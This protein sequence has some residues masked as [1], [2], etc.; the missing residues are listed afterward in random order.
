MQILFIL[1]RVVREPYLLSFDFVELRRYDPLSISKQ[2]EQTLLEG[3]ELSVSPFL[4]LLL[5]GRT[6]F[7]DDFIQFLYRG[8]SGLCV[9][10]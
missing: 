3:V 5:E 1:L 4:I 2:A 8:V 7:R 10:A 9:S 6:P